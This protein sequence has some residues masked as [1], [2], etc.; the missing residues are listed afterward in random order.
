MRQLGINKSGA[1]CHFSKTFPLERKSVGG[2]WMWSCVAAMSTTPAAREILWDLQF[3]LQDMDDAG[4]EFTLVI[5]NTKVNPHREAWFRTS[6]VEHSENGRVHLFTEAPYPIFDYDQKERKPALE[7]CVRASCGGSVHVQYTKL[8]L[9]PGLFW[10]ESTS[11]VGIPIG[12][13]GRLLWLL[14]KSPEFI[15]FRDVRHGDFACDKCDEWPIVGPRHTL[16]VDAEASYDLC[17]MC[18]RAHQ[19][20]HQQAHQRQHHFA[21]RT[22]GAAPP[23]QTLPTQGQKLWTPITGVGSIIMIPQPSSHNVTQ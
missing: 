5:K 23:K 20:D 4:S 3:T 6:V 19:R 12:R 9:R 11:G 14:G 17:E 16:C 13:Q 18:Y 1:L 22:R 10:P 15:S 2:G 8:R 21:G 7:F